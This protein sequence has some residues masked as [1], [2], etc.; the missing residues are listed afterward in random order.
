MEPS[1]TESE[2]LE[3]P[4]GPA[5]DERIPVEP[6][7]GAALLLSGN[8]S[9]TLAD[10]VFSALSQ[11][12]IGRVTAGL[13]RLKALPE[14]QIERMWNRLTALFTG[15]WRDEEDLVGFI[16]SVLRKGVRDEAPLQPVQKLAILLMALPPEVATGMTA[17]VTAGLDRTGMIELTREMAHLLHYATPAVQERV[18]GEFRA[19][20]ESRS[21][22]SV[23]FMHGTWMEIEAERLVRRYTASAA[24][25]VQRL[26]VAPA[27]PLQMFADSARNHPERTAASLC[28]FAYEPAAYVY[29]PR[30]GRLATFRACLSGEACDFLDTSIGVESSGLPEPF[31]SPLRKEIVLREFLHRFYLEQMKHIPVVM[32]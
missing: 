7:V 28:A 1:T 32:Q 16:R 26:W 31:G 21:L 4:P 13:L 27:E 3:Q 8:Y 10:R 6:E 23:G 18:V 24:D 25:L 9:R 14:A 11:E 22:Q 17:R 29:I 12:E 20:C 15:D 30:N 2:P 5:S 19:F